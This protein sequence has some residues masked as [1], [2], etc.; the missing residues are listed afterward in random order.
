MRLPVAL[1]PPPSL[2]D[3]QHA[4]QHELDRFGLGETPVDNAWTVW[5]SDRDY[6]RLDPQLVRW[7]AML[8]SWLVDRFL[9]RGLIPAGLVTVSFAAAAELEP[10]R[11]RLASQARKEPP[12]VVVPPVPL[13]GRPRLTV[14]A[15]G[16]A[17]W[18]SP[19]SAGIDS[20]LLLW[21]GSFVIGSGEGTDLRL[22]GPEVA[23]RH[24]VLEA[25]P[26]GGVQLHD[27][28]STTGTLVDG[29]P[30]LEVDLVDGNRIDMGG[31]TLVF[32]RDHLHDEGGREGGELEGPPVSP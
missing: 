10:G 6:A 23:P 28:G 14:P 25:A 11:F 17:P 12:K 31:T 15:G 13:P 20:E 21:P 3:V 4:L 7:G 29:V 30:R 24:A 8:Q 27:L 1:R 32:R 26:D 2:D 18:G 9:H 22:A 16:E 5:L 19:A